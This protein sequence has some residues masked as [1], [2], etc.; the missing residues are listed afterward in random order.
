MISRADDPLEVSHAFA[1][2]Y[3]ALPALHFLLVQLAFLAQMESQ[4]S[5]GAK[6]GTRMYFSMIP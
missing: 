5:T 1:C 2:L 3:Y 4:Q 6:T